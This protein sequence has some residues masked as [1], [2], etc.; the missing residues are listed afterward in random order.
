MKKSI[1]FVASIVVPAFILAGGLANSA[2]AQDKAAKPA[3]ARKILVENDKVQVTVA[4]YKPGV[5]ND[6]PQSSKMRVAR[7]LKGGTMERT[8]ADGKKE[9][10]VWKT[11]DV[12]ILEPGPAFT[13]VNI[14]KTDVELYTVVLK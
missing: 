14:G 10:I 6:V 3:D 11:G 7:A 5:R 9:K 1:G 8:Y 4:A 12:R 13:N 2:M